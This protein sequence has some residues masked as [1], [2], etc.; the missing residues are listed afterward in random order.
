MSAPAFLPCFFARL[1]APHTTYCV[2]IAGVT[3]V[4][5]F[6]S[7]SQAEIQSI[8]KT[9]PVLCEIGRVGG[10]ALLFHL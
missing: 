8:C 10:Q 2:S 3:L 4:T 7:F 5:V 1:F 6:F 9:Y